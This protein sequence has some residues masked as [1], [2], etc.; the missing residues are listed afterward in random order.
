[1]WCKFGSVALTSASSGWAQQE[2]TIEDLLNDARARGFPATE[3]L[4]HDWVA[5]GLLDHPTRRSRGAKG[6]SEKALWSAAQ[7]NTFRALVDKRP[8]VKGITALCNVPVFLWLWWGEEY[9]ATRQAR[10]ALATWAGKGAVSLQAARRQAREAT[11]FL[12]DIGASRDQRDRLVKAL[13]D[14][15]YMARVDRNV[16]SDAIREV[17]DPEG[18]GRTFGS[19]LM[20]MSIDD[21]VDLISARLLGMRV[22]RQPAPLD[23]L[24]RAWDLCRWSMQR[25]QTDRQALLTSSIR[26]QDAQLWQEPTLDILGNRACAQVALVLG[27]LTLEAERRS[28]AELQGPKW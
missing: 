3:R 1:M 16:L 10:Q 15:S 17:F 8:Q 28:K 26:P 12:D 24:K 6:G 14:T 5:L 23:M 25:Y 9:V 2:G 22:A 20:P 13:S 11:E 18:G 21:Y 7:R 4:I 19:S 27:A